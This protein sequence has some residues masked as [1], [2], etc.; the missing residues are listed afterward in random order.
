MTERG[1]AEDAGY[2]TESGNHAA[3]GMANDTTQV[4]K[5]PNMD[6]G[7][8]QSGVAGNSGGI[9]MTEQSIGGQGSQDGIR[10][11]PSGTQ[12]GQS[13]QGVDQGGRSQQSAQGQPDVATDK[14]NRQSVQLDPQEPNRNEYG[15]QQTGATSGE[16][17][18]GQMS[19]Q[20]LGETQRSDSQQS[21][22]HSGMQGSRGAEAGHDIDDI[23]GK[24]SGGGASRGED[25][26]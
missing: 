24:R 17:G 11:T 14:G 12:G 8:R 22:R 20:R 18:D 26:R 6:N 23:G 3:G 19:G 4:N 15:D 2:K 16:V 13:G 9:D 1:K 10:G 21:D 25:Q 5:A 7:N